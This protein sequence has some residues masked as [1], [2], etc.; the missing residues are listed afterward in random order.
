MR[1]DVIVLGG[2]AALLV[3]GLAIGAR[4]YQGAKQE[5]IATKV[6]SGPGP[7]V[8]V[9]PHSHTLGPKDAKVTV[10]EFLDP[11]CESCRAMYPIVKQV[12]GLYS[13]QVRLV[14]RYMPLHPNA[15]AAASALEAAGEQGR[16]WEMLE[17]MFLKQPEWADHHAP[18]PEL[19]P[20]YA[21]QVGLDMA[22]WSKSAADPAQR[23]KI[24]QD[25]ADGRLLGVNGTPTFFI[26]GKELERLGPEPLK[27]AIDAALAAR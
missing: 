26:N 19:L 10:V 9:R 18:K 25:H 14:I 17:L 15:V 8:F 7:E 24:D 23:K 11:E 3:G 27:A 6:A 5:E 13:G 4:F 21:R 2:I 20:E 12:M 22:A 1:K 16:Y